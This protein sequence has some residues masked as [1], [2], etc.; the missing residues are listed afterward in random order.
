MM[1]ALSSSA[2]SKNAIESAYI[3]LGFTNYGIYD[4]NEFDTYRCGYSIALKDS[5][6]DND[7]IC[8]ITFRGSELYTD[9]VGDFEINTDNE[10]HLGFYRPAETVYEHIKTL[11]VE[12]FTSDNVKY[13]ITG[14][15]RGAAVANLLSVELMENGVAAKNIYNYNFACPDVACKNYF[16]SYYN[17]FNLCNRA[18]PVPSLLGALCNAYTSSGTSWGKFGQTY[19]FT[20]FA[21]N[22]ENIFSGHGNKVYLNFFDQ[23]LNI[24]DWPQDEYDEYYDIL[25]KEW[26]WVTRISCPV[27][28]IV[29]DKTGKNIASVTNGEINYYDSKF[30]GVIIFTDGDKKIIYTN[31]DKD[32]N[33]ELIGTD[34]G[35]MTYSIEKYNLASGEISES[36]TFDN[37]AL[38]DGKTM[39]SPVSEA[40]Q[41]KD[42]QLFVTEEKNG[43]LV[44]THIINEDGVEETYY[45][46]SI[47]TPSTTTIRHKDGIILHLDIEGKLP[48]NSK[49]KWYVSN[50]NFDAGY[51][52]DGMSCMFIS[53]NNG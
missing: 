50:D 51:L 41:T 35:T 21:E 31:G 49:I 53:K 39:Y 16:P 27:D 45:T 2:Y 28:V 23:K 47:Q 15:S 20:N 4:Y 24:S 29:S 18:D 33:V 30:G 14:H 43:E 42:I 11:I 5:E 13:F 36:K 19:W 12:G 44:Y 6:Y 38:A 26:G 32:F 1:M 52:D 37:V 22:T 3:S 25:Y 34:T 48:E 17:I 40:E 8:I 46:F 9:W 10:K 7:K